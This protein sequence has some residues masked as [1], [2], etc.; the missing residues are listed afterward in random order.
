M[1]A[2]S[3]VGT[4]FPIFIFE[5]VNQNLT[6]LFLWF[7][8][9]YLLRIPFFLIGAKI[10]TRIG[11]KH[12]MIIGVVLW[13]FYYA[14]GLLLD[15]QLGFNANIIL[16]TSFV[17]LS[18]FHGL[19]WAPF[20]VDFATFTKKGHRGREVSLI[21][22]LR[23]VISI[24]IP[25]LAAYLITQYSFSSVFIVGIVFGL[26]SIIPLMFLPNI[27]ATYEYGV[28]ETF[29]K[30]FSKKFSHL[31]VAMIGEGAQSTVGYIA[32][33]VFLFLIFKGEYL[34]VGIF[35]S[36]IVFGSML[37]QL[38]LGKQIDKRAPGAFLS[39]G[40][41]IYSLGWFLKAFVESV[42]GVFLASTFHAFGSILLA[43][44]LETIVY[45]QAADA[46]HYIDE[47]TVI[48]EMGLT[49]GRLAMA[50]FLAI[51][52]I[53]FPLNTAFVVAA[54]SSLFIEFFSKVNAAKQFAK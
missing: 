29:K 54:L 18:G 15:L 42:T 24:F 47:F 6:V 51:I 26:V 45:Q 33:P 17:F 16:F 23:R 21:H 37:I 1:M 19:Y 49:V 31:T 13:A 22:V 39:W 2:F 36:I 8:I 35:S 30:L 3:I 11:L 9:G 43:A 14:G 53:W 28:I 27:E 48:R 20:H 41:R 34:N 46:G 32:W 52:T 4:F 7:S 50:A 44:P 38:F 10:F 25:I 12:S 40:S 5:L